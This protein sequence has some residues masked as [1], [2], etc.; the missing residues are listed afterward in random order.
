MAVTILLVTIQVNVF[1]NGVVNADSAIG[2]GSSSG[3]FRSGDV[4]H[5]STTAEPPGRSVSR[6]NN[7]TEKTQKN[8]S[9]TGRKNSASRSVHIAVEDSSAGPVHERREVSCRDGMRPSSSNGMKDRRLNS[10]TSPQSPH[11]HE[12]KTTVSSSIILFV[13]FYVL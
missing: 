6:K 12:V 2:R 1:L 10:N 7:H 5:V 8:K 13:I 9:S 4:N 3:H 11:A